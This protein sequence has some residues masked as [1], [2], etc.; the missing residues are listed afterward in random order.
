MLDALRSTAKTWLSR[1]VDDPPLPG[2][3]TLTGLDAEISDLESRHT[4]HRR[5]LERLEDEYRDAV[6]TAGRVPGPA[7]VDD[8][9]AVDAR[10]EVERILEAFV[11]RHRRFER[12]TAALRVLRRYWLVAHERASDD[13]PDVDVD[14]PSLD[15]GGNPPLTRDALEDWVDRVLDEGLPP[16]P[17]DAIDGP[18]EP[19]VT[20]LADTAVT[21]ARSTGEVPTLYALLE[22]EDDTDGETIDV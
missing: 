2:S 17:P 9:A 14:H 19:C 3:L 5:A 1:W 4:T 20:D 13:G 6:E 22:A 8:P 12:T 15:T 7:V 11:D 18:G 16:H 21:A 10:L